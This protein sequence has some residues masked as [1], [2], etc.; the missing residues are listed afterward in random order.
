MNFR[1]LDCEFCNEKHSAG[2]RDD[3]LFYTAQDNTLPQPY[4]TALLA[5]EGRDVYFRYSFA[6]CSH[7][8]AKLQNTTWQE[9]WDLHVPIAVAAKLEGT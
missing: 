8:R 5:Q 3:I 6:A 4:D 2:S 9:A 1:K 7:C